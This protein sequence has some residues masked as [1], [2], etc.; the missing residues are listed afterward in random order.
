MI[1]V[2]FELNEN[3]QCVKIMCEYELCTLTF[4]IF[5]AA[6]DSYHDLYIYLI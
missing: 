6:G 1:P 2:V 5:L 4:F 3:P